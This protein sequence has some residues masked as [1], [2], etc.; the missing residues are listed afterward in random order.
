LI[1]KRADPVTGTLVGT[2][3]LAAFLAPAALILALIVWLAVRSAR[4]KSTP[5][6]PDA[7]TEFS[8]RF[9]SL[10]DEILDR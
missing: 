2:I 3:V 1:P 5:P 10:E 6:K 9:Q 4:S 8:S 7:D